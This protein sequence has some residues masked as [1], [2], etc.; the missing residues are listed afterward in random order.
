MAITWRNSTNAVLQSNEMQ[1]ELEGYIWRLNKTFKFLTFA[2][3]ES[4]DI[5]LGQNLNLSF[6][7][8]YEDY[9]NGLLK[10]SVQYFNANGDNAGDT[11]T[12]VI[13]NQFNKT[14]LYQFSVGA[15]SYPVGAVGFSVSIIQTGFGIVSNKYF[16]YIKERCEPG[17]WIKWRNLLGG[18]E[19]FIMTSVNSKSLR[20]SYINPFS[21]DFTSLT[22]TNNVNRGFG[23]KEGQILEFG[24]HYFINDEFA[25]WFKNDVA[26]STDIFIVKEKNTV[27]FLQ[28]VKLINTNFELF[29][30][31]VNNKQVFLEFEY[32]ND[33][34]INQSSGFNDQ[35]L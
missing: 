30:S 19:G 6:L 25:N 8:K 28:P 11:L 34:R 5:Y 20:T 17:V 15:T 22:G 16:Y 4:Q 18:W 1:S 7:L 31:F 21:I 33:V 9:T 10:I 13:P 2:K 32:N 23:S 24:S 12:N 29:N 3:P 35:F 26:T 14:V 27:K